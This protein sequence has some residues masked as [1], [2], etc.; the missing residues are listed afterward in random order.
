M[1]EAVKLGDNPSDQFVV[2][3]GAIQAAKEGGSLPLCFKAADA[4]TAVF[5][6]DG[7]AVKADAA[8]KAA[9]KADAT[10]LTAENVRAGLELMG[11]LEAADDL[12]GASK[13]GTMLSKA[14]TTVALK[15]AVLNR[16]KEVEEI[17]SAKEKVKGAVE[18]FNALLEGVWRIW[19]WDRVCVFISGNGRRA[20]L[21]WR[22]ERMR[23]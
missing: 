18:K 3:G 6:L 10:P 14:A 23:S 7:L 15:T 1:G 16:S 5:E 19:R 21:C 4:M 20:C 2:L 22:R 9:I 13:V 12:D 8:L 17:R 11:Q